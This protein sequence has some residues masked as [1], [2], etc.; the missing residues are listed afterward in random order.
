MNFQE[1]KNL[2]FFKKK[3]INFQKN[4]NKKKSHD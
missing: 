1:R 2:L 3:F 4:K